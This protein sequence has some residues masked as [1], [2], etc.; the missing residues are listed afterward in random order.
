M[1]TRRNTQQVY[2]STSDPATS[3]ETTQFRNELGQ[4]YIDY[5]GRWR[6]VQMDSVATEAIA[7]KKP[8]YVKSIADFI[9]TTDLTD[10]QGNV[11]TPA[12]IITTDNTLPAVSQYFWMLERGPAQ[13]AAGGAINF[14]AIGGWITSSAAGTVTYTAPG[15]AAPRAVFG[16]VNT[17]VDRSGG[18][19]DVV[20][21]LNVT[22]CVWERT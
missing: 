19:G 9:V 16:T 17:A 2:L 8:L 5:R 20:I 13:T 1:E 22:P 4:T 12:G 7:A 6:K 10:S 14:A 15:T 3:V 18:A 11:N 21:D